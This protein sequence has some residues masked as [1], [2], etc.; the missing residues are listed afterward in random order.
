MTKYSPSF[1][2]Q[3]IKFIFNTVKQLSDPS[4]FLVCELAKRR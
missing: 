2:Q 3:A 4:A 1:K